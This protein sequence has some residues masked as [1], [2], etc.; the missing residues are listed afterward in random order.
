M[1]LRLVLALFAYAALG[2]MAWRTMESDGFRV[3]TLAILAFFAA[4]T[5][6]HGF[7][8]RQDG[9]VDDRQEEGNGRH[10]G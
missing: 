8:A 2:F 7:R 1:S 10:V 3:A 6:M 5:V 9:R 4:R